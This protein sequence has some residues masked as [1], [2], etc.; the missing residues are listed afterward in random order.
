MQLAVLFADS[1]Q[2]GSL[3]LKNPLLPAA[4]SPSGVNTNNP[5]SSELLHIHAHI[6]IFQAAVA[7][8]CFYHLA[9]FHL[10]SF[11]KNYTCDGS[12][13]RL[14]VSLVQELI[15]IVGGFFLSWFKFHPEVIPAKD[16][17][18]GEVRGCLHK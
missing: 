18:A 6:T 17:N 9:R 10:K 8:I 3:D 4:Q 12:L 7:V 15:G 14:A 16:Q 11:G 2:I 13:Y 5:W 1:A